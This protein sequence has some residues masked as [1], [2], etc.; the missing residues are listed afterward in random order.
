MLWLTWPISLG[1][2]LELKVIFINETKKKQQQQQQH[3]NNNNNNNNKQTKQTR[4]HKPS[5]FWV[6]ERNDLSAKSRHYNILNNAS[7]SNLT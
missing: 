1:I 6:I 4:E 2:V 7:K 3:N 5:Y